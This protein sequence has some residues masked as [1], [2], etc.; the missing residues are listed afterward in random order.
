MHGPAAQDQL[1]RLR[2]ICLEL[3]EVTERLS[4]GEPTWFVR[5]KKTLA[6]F[7]SHHHDDRLAF[8]CPA[9]QGAQQEMVAAEPDRFFVPPYVGGRGWLGVRLDVSVDWEEVRRIIEEAYRAVAPTKL[10]KRLDSPGG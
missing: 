1:E 6:T 3:P 8:W 7:A 4:H 10:V 2:A 9:P 5:G